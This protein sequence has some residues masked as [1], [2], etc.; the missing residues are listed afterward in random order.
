MS[1]PG[2]NEGRRQEAKDDDA[3]YEKDQLTARYKG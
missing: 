2:V 3:S 1:S